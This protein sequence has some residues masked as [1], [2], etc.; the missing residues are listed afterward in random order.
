MGLL[1]C[2]DIDRGADVAVL[3]QAQER[4][5]PQIRIACC[6]RWAVVG[7]PERLGLGAEEHRLGQ[8]RVGHPPRLW[9]PSP[10]RASANE[11]VSSEAKSRDRI[12][13]KPGATTFPAFPSRLAR[14]CSSL[15]PGEWSLTSPLAFPHLPVRADQS[16]K[17]LQS[18]PPP[19][20]TIR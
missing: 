5:A 4:V 13:E 11:R 18:A 6:H 19:A 17:S 9:I 15:E 14:A 10:S 16:E 7:Q 2:A 3:V 20:D 8:S 12:K 1:Q